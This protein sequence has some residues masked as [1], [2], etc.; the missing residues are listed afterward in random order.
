MTTEIKSNFYVVESA[1][2]QGKRCEMEDRILIDEHFYIKDSTV[3]SETDDL[4]LFA[5]FDGHGGSKCVKYVTFSFKSILMIALQTTSSMEEAFVKT[6]HLLDTTFINSYQDRSGTTAVVVLINNTTKDL[7][8][9]H[10]GDSRA[11]YGNRDLVF[12]LTIDHKG[13]LQSEIYRIQKVGGHISYGRVN[14]CL[15]V[16][17][18]IGDSDYKE[19]QKNI[20]IATPEVKKC[21]IIQYNNFDSDEQSDKKTQD[22][23][24]LLAS[25]GLFDVLSTIDII[26]YITKNV[27]QKNKNTLSSQ[28]VSESINM[29]NSRDNVSIILITLKNH[30]LKKENEDINLESCISKIEKEEFTDEDEFTGEEEYGDTSSILMSEFSDVTIV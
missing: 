12:N 13:T 16:T 3:I 11:I 28:L 30:L 29:Y 6:F 7:W 14:G 17:R 18:A 21:K 2:D 23:Y 19:D 9:A 1:K 27:N 25:D 24:I 4:S 15:A 20:V 10:A 26:N 5:V 8:V 22:S